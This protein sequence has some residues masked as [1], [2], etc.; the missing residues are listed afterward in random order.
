MFIC[1]FSSVRVGAAS[2]MAS[3]IFWRWGKPQNV[4]LVENAGCDFPSIVL[5]I[6]FANM[7]T[8][9]VL[10]KE[11]SSYAQIS[12]TLPRILKYVHQHFVLFIPCFPIS[13]DPLPPSCNPSKFHR[14]HHQGRTPA[15]N[16]FA[17]RQPLGCEVGIA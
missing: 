7:M 5:C 1:P 9:V 13:Q 6:F 16:A 15:H 2:K 14:S 8:M 3:S 17:E 11:G 10:S 4:L 12:L